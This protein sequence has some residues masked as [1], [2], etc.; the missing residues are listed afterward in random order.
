MV[1]FDFC[2]KT[3]DISLIS[4]CFLRDTF[5]LAKRDI[6]VKVCFSDAFKVINPKQ[7]F[8]L[9]KAKL[10]NSLIFKEILRENEIVFHPVSL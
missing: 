5:Y 9:Y 4:F 10:K 7:I 2:R 1:K 3:F 8:S 6:D